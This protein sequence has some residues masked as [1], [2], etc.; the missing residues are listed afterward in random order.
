MENSL[1]ANSDAPLEEQL[2]SARRLL[3]CSILV[4]LEMT[5][6]HQGLSRDEA[7]RRIW[8]VVLALADEHAMADYA[9]CLTVH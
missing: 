9:N 8:T 6:K 2:K 5:M 1:S 3:G 4:L 7:E